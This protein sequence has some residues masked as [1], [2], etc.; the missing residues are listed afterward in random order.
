MVLFK[1]IL[2]GPGPQRKSYNLNDP[3]LKVILVFY[4]LYVMH[5]NFMNSLLWGHTGRKLQY[6]DMY[7]LKVSNQYFSQK[8]FGKKMTAVQ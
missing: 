2:K 4:N 7:L 5:K 8:S 6:I 1:D 3:D